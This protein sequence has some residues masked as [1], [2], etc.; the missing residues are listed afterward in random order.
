MKF[1]FYI[2]IGFI[3]LF[4]SSCAIAPSG[5]S[6]DIK[7]PQAFENS[8]WSTDHDLK[9]VRTDRNFEKIKNSA[10]VILKLNRRLQKDYHMDPN[11]KYYLDPPQI[12]YQKLESETLYVKL[13][14]SEYV[15]QRMGTTGADVFMVIATFT[16]TEIDGVKN[17]YFEFEEGDHAHPGK[18]SRDDEIFKQFQFNDR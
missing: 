15:T 8:Y 2:S 17:V 4:L 7:D 13:D 5:Y 3:I 9:L 12:T 14:N 6:S 16:L 18:Y 1:K 10:D 11:D